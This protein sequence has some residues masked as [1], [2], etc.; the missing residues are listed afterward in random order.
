[1]PR[2][3][4]SREKKELRKEVLN[5]FEILNYALGENIYCGGMVASEAMAS[6]LNNQSDKNSLMFFHTYL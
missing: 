5:A 1:M 6:W 3:S 2:F 4:R